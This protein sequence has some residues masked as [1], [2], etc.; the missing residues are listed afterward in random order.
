MFRQGLHLEPQDNISQGWSHRD[1]EQKSM[2]EVNLCGF[3]HHLFDAERNELFEELLT[4]LLFSFIFM[5]IEISF[6]KKND[7][8]K[9][10]N[11]IN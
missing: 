11:L 4:E 10:K 8:K 6:W 2:E 1:F 9:N 7:K 5:K 3:G